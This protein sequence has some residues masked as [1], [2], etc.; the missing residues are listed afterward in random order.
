MPITRRP[1]LLAGALAASRSAWAQDFPTRPVRIIVPNAAGGTEVY[2]RIVQ[3][4]FARALGQPAV[5]ESIPGGGGAV[6]A[7]R[8]RISPADGYT[9]LF[10]SHAAISL[11]PRIQKLGWS[12]V[13]FAPICN[14]M[15]IPIVVAARRNAPFKTFQEMVSQAKARPE[16]ITMASPGVGSTP[17]LA[18]ELMQRAAGI[19]LLHVPY[20]GIAPALTGLV[21]GEVDTIVGAP[22]VFMPAVQSQ[23]IS[24]LA[25]TGARRIA[26]LPDL[27]TLKEI[28]L[29]IDIAARFA[30]FAPKT[31]PEPV[32]DRLARAFLDVGGTPT[33]AEQMQ[34]GYNEVLLMDRA[35]LTAA[36]AVEERV[37]ELLVQEL[38]LTAG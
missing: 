26:A 21:S 36:M 10:G 14:L 22:G 3:Q 25:Q 28:G 15:A 2:I 27:T 30:F 12:A 16:S 6:G 23:G 38:G 37:N 11:V 35:Q 18:G 19:K 34:R 7:N 31:T 17:H 8:V 9:I 24:L 4:E 5:I 29:D 20:A 33:Y 1:L 32:L 13:D